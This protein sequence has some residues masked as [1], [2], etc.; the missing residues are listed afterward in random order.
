MQPMLA[1]LLAGIAS[2]FT[3]AMY[4]YFNY[5]PVLLQLPIH[6]VIFIAGYF[7]LRR[8]LLVPKFSVKDWKPL[9]I[10]LIGA[11]PIHLTIHALLIKDIC[12]S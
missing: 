1:F 9:S 6:A 2:G 12:C 8:F 7:L 11:L 4:L 10:Y 5:E 3:S